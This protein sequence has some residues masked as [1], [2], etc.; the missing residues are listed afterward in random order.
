CEEAFGAMEELVRAG[1]I[2]FAGVSN[3]TVEQMERCRAVRP[4]DVVQVGYHLFDRRMEREI[5]PYCRTHGIGV[6]GYGSLGHGLLTGTFTAGTPFPDPHWPGPRG[7]LRPPDP[8]P[9]NPEAKPAAGVRP[10][11]GG[12]PAH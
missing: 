12:E 4:V 3:F 1:K 8:Q 10:P 6:M 5:F 9:P 2:R 11:A 7:G